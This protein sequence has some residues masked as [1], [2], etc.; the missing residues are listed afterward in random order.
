MKRLLL[1]L[2]CSGALLCGAGLSDVRTVYLMP[3]G[4]GLDQYLMNRLTNEHVLQ[5]VVDPKLADAVLTDH[6]GEDFKAKLEEL[7]PTPAPPKPE[8]PDKAEKAEKEPE[9]DSGLMTLS[10]KG[11]NVDHPATIGR[12][13]GTVFLVDAKSRRLIW[14]VYELPKSSSSKDLDRTASDIVSRLKNDLNP[15]KK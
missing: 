14:S 2:S 15:R 11:S 12:A 3:M 9:Q 6:L 5:V 13:R 8:K 7:F 1:V 10:A 4:H